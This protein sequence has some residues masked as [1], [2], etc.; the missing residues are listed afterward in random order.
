M[1]ADS[2]FT[3]G[4]PWSTGGGWSYD[5]DNDNMA[6]DD[7]SG[8]ELEQIDG[9]MLASLESST[10]YALRFTIA[11]AGVA[12]IAFENAAGDG[13]ISTTTYADG[14]HTIYFKSSVDVG[15]GGF[16]FDAKTAESTATFTLDDVYLAERTLGAEM[17]T[18]GT[19]DDSDD[20]VLGANWA[21][22][23]GTANYTDGTSNDLEQTNAVMASAITAS[24]YYRISF[25]I[26]AS[27]SGQ[28]DIECYGGG[29][30]YVSVNN[31]ATGHYDIDFTSP[32]DV[33]TAGIRFDTTSN[34][35]SDF[36]ID[37]ISLK[38]WSLLE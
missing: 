21:I 3:T 26:T 9:N 38:K 35:E 15:A 24:T 36:S 31:Y 11:S 7:I 12:G 2:S 28:F 33:G 30:V 8:G 32:A 4:T 13:L 5:S 10:H 37:N 23:G 29:I 18:N 6:F 27:V 19:F 20:W 22:A 25:D 1:L 14:T 34:S 17:I 16:T